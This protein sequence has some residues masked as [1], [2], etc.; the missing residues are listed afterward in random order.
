[1]N[2]HLQN[3]EQMPIEIASTQ[4]AKSPQ[5]KQTCKLSSFA[6]ISLLLIVPVYIAMIIFADVQKYKDILQ[7][8]ATIIAG[9][10][11]IGSPIIAVIAKIRIAFSDGRLEGNRICNIIRNRSQFLTD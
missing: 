1:M 9:F 3:S 10:S 6:A 2:E 11:V 7:L 4:P 5:K 8:V